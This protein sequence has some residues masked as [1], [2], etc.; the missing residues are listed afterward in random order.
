MNKPLSLPSFPLIFLVIFL[1]FYCTRSEKENDNSSEDQ[2]SNERTE[3]TP[4]P[5]PWNQIKASDP[6][7]NNSSSSSEEELF[8][9]EIGSSKESLTSQYQ[10]ALSSFLQ[11][12]KECLQSNYQKCHEILSA[13]WSKYPTGDLS[14]YNLTSED[15]DMNL[16]T[17]P[18]Y[19]ALRML[20]DLA[21]LN[22]ESK[23]EPKESFLL[24]VILV[25]KSESLMPTSQN[26]LT[27]ST[28]I[29]TIENLHTSLRDDENKLLTE[30]LRIFKEYVLVMSQGLKSLKVNYLFVDDYQ[31][32]VEIKF[33]ER[34]FATPSTK[35]YTELWSY[36]D[37]EVKAKTD[38]WW[39]IYPSQVPDR[40]PDFA[41]S[42]FVTGGMGLGEQGIK[43]L[44]IIDDLW[45]IRRPPH[46]GKGLYTSLERRVYLPQ[47][48]QHEFFH[49]LFRVYPI[50]EL[51]KES[52]QWF[53]K[54][55]WPS[56]FEGV[57][58]ADYYHESLFKRILDT[59]DPIPS[60]HLS[61]K[62]PEES[63]WKEVPISGICGKYRHLPYQNE[64]HEGTIKLKDSNESNTYVWKNSAGVSWNLTPNWTKGTL[65]TAS[66]SPYYEADPLRGRQFIFG[67][68]K[69]KAGGFNPKL[70]GFTFMGGFYQLIEE[71]SCEGS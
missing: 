68:E 61:Y 21:E 10:D 11:A 34:Y 23:A 47:W 71:H 65:D 17:P 32:P 29:K 52:H 19:Y 63:L 16:G 42:E 15:G 49:H 59:G 62:A 30:S 12:E 69:I 53:D 43:P 22:L 51:E 20:S 39:L 28:G 66:T 35:G 2:I 27:K 70:T 4:L 14:W 41:T 25:G 26:D 54:I 3:P 64:W 40:Y 33:D 48:L 31:I 9:N 37:D 36:I 5:N 6:F 67:L 60:I 45:L 8:F 7:N 18:F 38:W 56:D 58:E 46:L 13:L 50:F 55:N 44:F 1:A 57:F 24:T